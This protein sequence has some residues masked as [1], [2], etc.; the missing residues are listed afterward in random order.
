MNSK[1]QQQINDLYFSEFD[2]DD[3]A[4]FKDIF[5]QHRGTLP[6]VADKPLLVLQGDRNFY[7]NTVGQ[8]V[9][10]S[11]DG[12]HSAFGVQKGDSLFVTVHGAD[13]FPGH[14]ALSGR[15]YKPQINAPNIK[16]NKPSMQIKSLNGGGIGSLVGGVV[17]GVAG[18]AVAKMVTDEYKEKKKTNRQRQNKDVQSQQIDNSYAMQMA[19]DISSYRYGKHMTGFVNY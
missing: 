14:I 1:L 2:A 4:Y 3:Y 9:E 8:F 5:N 13:N 6:D 15:A 11:M 7:N 17:V 12:M 10:G 16:P 19:Q 18:L